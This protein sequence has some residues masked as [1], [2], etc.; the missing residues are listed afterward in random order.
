VPKVSKKTDALYYIE[1]I[2]DIVKH[3]VS[4]YPILGYVQ[5]CLDKLRDIVENDLIE[6]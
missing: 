6:K 1:Q 5:E 3:L 2:K 4:S